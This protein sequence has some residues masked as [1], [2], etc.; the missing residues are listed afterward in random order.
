MITIVGTSHV[1]KQSAQDVRDAVEHANIIAIELDAGRA[2][3][4]LSGKRATFTELRR[5]LGLRAATI[6][7]ILRFAQERIAAA[8]GVVPGVE[9]KEALLLAAKQQKRVAFIDRE[10]QITAQRLTKALGWRELRQFCKDLLKPKKVSLH[11][12][13]EVVLALLTELKAKYPRVY[14]AVVSE[15]DD[16]MA[17]SL[18]AVQ[19]RNPGTSIVAVVGKGHVPGMLERINYLNADA[20]VSVWTSRATKPPR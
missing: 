4:L 2:H 9:M 7:S 8:V 3:A 17:R 20:Q 12:T 5:A 15:R 10:I 16:H 6:A 18:L 14:T 11:P 19:E 13:D 1:S